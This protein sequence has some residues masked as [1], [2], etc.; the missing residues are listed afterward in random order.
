M[1]LTITDHH[2]FPVEAKHLGFSGGERH[3]QLAPSNTVSAASFTIRAAIRNSDDLLDLVLT[4]NA[5]EEAFGSVPTQIEIPYLPYARQDRVCAPGQAFSLKVLVRLLGLGPHERLAV[6][7]CHSPVGIELTNA[8]N[9]DASEIVRSHSDLRNTILDPNTVLVCPDKGA[10]MRCQSMAQALGDCELIF[11]DKVRDP[12]TGRILRTDV[13]VDDLAG[14]TAVITDDIC[15][16]GMTFIKIAEQLRVKN[17]GSV[18]LFVT[19]G[20]FSKG[21]DVFDG[22][23]DHIYTTNSFVQVTDPRVTCIPYTYNFENH[24]RNPGLNNI[25]PEGL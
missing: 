22:L 1:P 2:G 15:D 25:E 19:H 21:L 12:A 3:V 7:D 18:I 13:L 17:A 11:C 9:V 8:I 4:R 5:L 24:G 10:R 20:I 6:W 14:K 16:G 23:I